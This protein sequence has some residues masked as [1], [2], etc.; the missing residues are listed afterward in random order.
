M[1]V[2]RVDVERSDD[3]VTLGIEVGQGDVKRALGEVYR[4]LSKEVNIP[5]FR[6]GK[7]P[8]MILKQ[9]FGEEVIGQLVADRIAPEAYKYAIKQA[10]VEP[11]D[12][13]KVE[14]VEFKEGTPLHFTATVAVRPEPELGEYGG[15]PAERR[16]REV[17]DGEI[18]RVVEA[19][20]TD[21]ADWVDA[22]E[23]GAEM[24]D[25]VI[26]R[27]SVSVQ[28]KPQ[29]D[30][31]ERDLD[32]V[33]G[34]GDTR[35]AVDYDLVGATA[36]ETRTFNVRY[37]EG[38]GDDS[39][40][41]KDGEFEVQ[42]GQVQV[43][44]LPELDDEFAKKVAEHRRTERDGV[45][46]RLAELRAAPGDADEA[47]ESKEPA[48]QGEEDPDEA[49]QLR[50]AREIEGV[51]SLEQ[52]RQLVRSRLEERNRQASNEEVEEE[53]V[54]VAVGRATVDAPAPMVDRELDS[55]VASM[56]RSVESRGIDFDDY[57]IASRQTE[58]QIRESMKPEAERY[59]RRVL[60]LDEIGR[61]ENIEVSDK[62]IDDRLKEMARGFGIPAESFREHLEGDESLDGVERAVSRRKVVEFLVENAEI[63]EVMLPPEEDEAQEDDGEGDDAEGAR[64]EEPDAEEL[65][66]PQGGQ[67]TAPEGGGAEND[68]DQE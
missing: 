14:A 59:V 3:T 53:V 23:H 49:E 65:T 57:L 62:E 36:G 32:V 56:R 40:A 30:G 26:G 64:G 33:L 55:R 20:R 60:V 7:V 31:Q 39:L 29:K 46:K 12:E 22:P 54:A 68:D 37:P 38:Y 61:Q 1:D 63:E 66:A 16:I 28:G 41:G 4:D 9:R 19:F 52:L 15:I 35:P 21:V 44:D 27:L 51:E 48:D 24:G 2:T 47:D 18:D 5:G 11:I 8:P 10:E 25:R 6:K 45:E 67:P 50:K 17:A 13:A 58:E 43:R 42:V 34:R